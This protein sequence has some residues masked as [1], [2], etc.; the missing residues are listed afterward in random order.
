MRSFR[1]GSFCE[2]GSLIGIATGVG[3]K[4]LPGWAEKFPSGLPLEEFDYSDVSISSEVT[5]RN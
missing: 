5:N 2:R 4:S 1:A 3:I